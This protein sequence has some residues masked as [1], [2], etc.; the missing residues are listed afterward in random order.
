M[1]DMQKTRN[2]QAYMSNAPLQLG[3]GAGYGDFFWDLYYTL[4]FS[5]SKYDKRTADHF[6]FNFQQ[7]YFWKSIWWNTYLRAYRGFRDNQNDQKYNR[8]NLGNIGTSLT[9][10]LNGESHSLRAVYNLDRVQ[11]ESNGS[12]LLGGDLYY[13]TIASKDGTLSRF[14]RK[15]SVVYGGPHIGYSHT[16]VAS[17]IF[18]NLFGTVGADLGYKKED[19]NFLFVVPAMTKLSVGYYGDI[20][21][22]Y[23]ALQA[24][25]QNFFFEI[26]QIDAITTTT[27]GVYLIRR[28]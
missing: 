22:W 11:H 20:W 16:W 8:L 5:L 6:V 24:E 21:S 17:D 12:W 4:P 15:R 1:P 23:M 3:L 25:I 9:Y 27:C 26:N 10:A 7:S 14:S 19:D 2:E 13:T 28:F 18:F